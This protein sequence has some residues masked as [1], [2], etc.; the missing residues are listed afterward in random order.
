VLATATLHSI[1]EVHKQMGNNTISR[2][3]A[4]L[5]GSTA[6]FIVTVVP[7]GKVKGKVNRV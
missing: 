3:T 1:S 7:C 2:M 6:I 5:A 4:V